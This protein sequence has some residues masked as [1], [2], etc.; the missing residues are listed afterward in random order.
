MRTHTHTHTHTHILVLTGVLYKD[1]VSF[2]SLVFYRPLLFRWCWETRSAAL[3]LWLKTEDHEMEHSFTS[4]WWLP[5]APTSWQ[6]KMPTSWQA[7]SELHGVCYT[8]LDLEW[9]VPTSPRTERMYSWEADISHSQFL[10][11]PRSTQAKCVWCISRKDWREKRM[12]FQ[13]TS[14]L[15]GNYKVYHTK[16]VYWQ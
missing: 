4:C 15:P 10:L 8:E 12:S 3:S 11:P 13:T 16:F 7:F 9:H 1:W 6:S 14:V 2:F 5:A